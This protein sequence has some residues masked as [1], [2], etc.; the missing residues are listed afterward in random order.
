M[1]IL[2]RQPDNLNFLSPLSFNLVL[3]QTPHVNYFCQQA[4][5]PGLT[6]DVVEQPSPNLRIPRP[7]NKLTFN[8]FS[9]TFAVDEDLEN[10]YEIINWMV[11]LGSPE[12]TKQ[13]VDQ[14]NDLRGRVHSQDSNIYSDATLLINSNVSNPNKAIRF[15]D[16]F[17]VSLSPLTF[18]SR[19]QAVTYLEADVS[20]RY[21]TFSLENA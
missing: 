19:D 11:G 16:C 7:G 3:D 5:L 8:E 2:S 9:V 12:N 17:P 10:Y 14:V 21:L 18:N 6:L 4:T 1:A 20:F 13:Y 15:K